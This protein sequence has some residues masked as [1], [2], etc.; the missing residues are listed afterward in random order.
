MNIT[1]R[2]ATVK[3]K[4]FII[5]AIIES[6]KSGSSIISYCAIFSIDEGSFRAIL[7]NI[8]DENME[9]QELCIDNFLIGEVDGTQ[10]AAISTWIE[11]E[12][13]MASNLVKSNLLMFFMDR[14]VI[15]NAAPSIAL[16]NEISIERDEHT[17][18]VECVYTA[19]QFRGL[20]LAGRLI[21]EHI[22]RKKMAGKAFEK[23]QII[24]LKNNVSA[25]RSYEK[26]G[27]VIKQERQCTDNAIFRLLPS[28]TKVLMEKQIAN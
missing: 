9:G 26:A 21:N 11:K 28:D 2:Q 18:Q 8:L 1:I 22:N 23:V 20:G 27:F 24:L 13:G 6:E 12:D 25:I 7:S 17:L 14:D 4:D 10:A 19:E 15:M 3:D 5:D 16:M